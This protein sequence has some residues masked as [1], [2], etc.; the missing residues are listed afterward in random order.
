MNVMSYMI[1]NDWQNT[2]TPYFLLQEKGKRWRPSF[3]ICLQLYSSHEWCCKVNCCALYIPIHSTLFYPNQ[4]LEYDGHP[5]S[6]AKT[7]EKGCTWYLDKY[8]LQT[9][10]VFFTVGMGSYY[11]FMK[12]QPLTGP[13]SI[14]QM[15]HEWIWSIGRIILAEES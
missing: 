12:L 1:D 5:V 14:P 13:L 3:M 15:I 11:V 4:I 2:P 8:S 9:I 7:L 6:Y 10:I